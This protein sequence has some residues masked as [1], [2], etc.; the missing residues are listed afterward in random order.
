[1]NFSYCLKDIEKFYNYYE[2][3]MK[4]YKHKYSNRILS[5]RYEKFI[6]NPREESK[7]IQLLW[8]KWDNSF[9]NFKDKKIIIKTSSFT[10]KK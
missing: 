7:N 3:L 1:M 8:F 9:L 5:V 4:Y 6:K 2:K 10:I